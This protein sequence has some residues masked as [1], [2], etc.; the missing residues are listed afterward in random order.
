M[1][2]FLLVLA[3]VYKLVYPL[4]AAAR[5]NNAPPVQ[6][7]TEDERIKGYKKISAVII[8]EAVVV[9]AICLIVGI[10]FNSL[11]LRRIDVSY[12]TWFTS[13]ALFICTMVLATNFYGMIAYIVSPKYREE[14]KRELVKDKNRAVIVLLT[15]RSWREKRYYFFVS[16]IS[17]IGEEIVFRGF[18][19]F[20][21]HAVFTEMPIPLVFILTSVVFGVAHAYQGMQG[22]IRKTMTGALYGGIFLVTGSLIPAMVVHFVLNFKDAFS[23]S[24]EGEGEAETAN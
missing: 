5:Q 9:L 8:I 21:I 18:I 24:D 23:L 13:V 1:Y 4:V 14:R 11:G 17:G 10:S 16:L 20:L 2:I 22:I 6:A 12:H 19:F 7:I 15:P 3:M